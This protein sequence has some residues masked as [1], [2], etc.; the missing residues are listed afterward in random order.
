MVFKPVAIIL[1]ISRSTMKVRQHLDE[2]AEGSLAAEHCRTKQPKDPRFNERLAVLP[3]AGHDLEEAD[4]FW[5]RNSTAAC[6]RI[7]SCFPHIG[8]DQVAGGAPVAAPP[9]SGPAPVQEESLC[10]SRFPG[11]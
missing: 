6:S 8:E 10:L 11:N 9:H 4:I 1:T 7:R 3:G 5:S 2:A